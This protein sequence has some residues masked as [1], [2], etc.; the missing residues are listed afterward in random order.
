VRRPQPVRA[1]RAALLRRRKRGEPCALIVMYH[2]IAP[3]GVDPWELA[4]TPE[5][6]SEHLEVLRRVARVVPLA[7]LAAERSAGQLIDRT[8]AVTF[9]DGYADNLLEAK[10]RLQAAD[11][12]ATVFVTTGP[13][14]TAREFWW[15]ELDR[16]LL[17]PAALPP[18]LCLQ[19]N[20]IERRW[21]LGDAVRG[22]WSHEGPARASAARLRFHHD[23]WH[24]L[25]PLPDLARQEAL[26][27]LQVW[28]GAPS[29]PR[30]SHRVMTAE[31]LVAIESDGTVE[32]GAHTVTHPLLTALPP[33]Q[34]AEE[35]RQSRDT[36][37]AILGHRVAS[38]SY[39]FGGA[40]RSTA[41][42][43]QSLGFDHAVT[44]LEE[45]MWRRS[46][47]FLLPRFAVR[48]WDGAQFEHRLANW[49]QQHVAP[50][51]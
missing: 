26:A 1:L 37:E 21:T 7:Q 31:E 19:V 50:I 33:D 47:P 29:A 10:P 25:R 14:G 38:F 12:P 17:L 36:L 40:D 3:V 49:F 44:V 20:G 43:A 8:V 15:D 11:I 34:Q 51:V 46:D 2:R 48:D 32:I 22:A 27:A 13:T 23:V 6:F 28:C 30:T 24:W 35:M 42:L 39:P 4:V 5:H 18:D 45:T 9:D 41:R 16:A